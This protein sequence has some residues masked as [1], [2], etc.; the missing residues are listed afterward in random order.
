MRLFG[1]IG[2]PLAHSFSKKYFTEKFEKERLTDC[3]YENFPIVSIDKIN[4]IL[5]NYPHLKGLNITIPYKEQVLPFLDEMSDT[6]SAIQACNCIKILNGKL[7]GH[8]TDVPAFEKSLSK[9]LLGER[10]D[11]SSHHKKALVLGAGG[12]AK[13]V[14]YVLKKMNFEYKTVSRKAGDD[15][16]TYEQVTTSLLEE[17]TLL[18]NTT[19]LGMF[20]DISMAPAIPY[21][22]LSSKHFLFDLIYNPEKTLFLQRGEEQGATIKNGMEMLILQAEESWWIWNS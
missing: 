15:R 18:I 2:Y 6:V 5:Q 16:L 14:E 7:S 8:N 3:A 20:P 9:G 1:I 11:L 22:A 19:P 21:E 10:K 12:S 13:A 17:Y 4:S